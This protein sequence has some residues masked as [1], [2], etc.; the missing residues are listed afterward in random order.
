MTRAN[1]S[2][3]RFDSDAQP[4]RVLRAALLAAVSAVLFGLTFPPTG[5]KGMEWVA[6]APFLVALR[7]GGIGQA[8][9]ISW[10]WCVVGASVAGDWFPRA[11]AQYFKQ[12]LPVALALFAGVFTFMA[13]PYFMVFGVAYRALARRFDLLL[14]FL[15]AAVLLLQN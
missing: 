1:G 7:Q 14:P 4:G 11:V 12:P 2:W 5:W 8:L 13:A 3:I 15:A 6:L 9:F 10:L